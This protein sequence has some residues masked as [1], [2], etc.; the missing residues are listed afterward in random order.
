MWSVT[1][2]MSPRNRIVMSAPRKITKEGARVIS[3]SAL[4]MFQKSNYQAR[5]GYGDRG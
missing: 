5:G 1:H 2:R 3:I 4:D